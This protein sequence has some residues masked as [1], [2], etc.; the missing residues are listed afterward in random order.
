M[1]FSNSQNQDRKA[2]ALPSHTTLHLSRIHGG[3][4]I[5]N[6][7]SAMAGSPICANAFAGNISDNDRVIVADQPPVIR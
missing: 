6:C 2:S 7:R 4:M 3:L 1:I 5:H